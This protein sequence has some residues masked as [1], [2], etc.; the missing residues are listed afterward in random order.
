[1]P[2]APL[3]LALVPTPGASTGAPLPANVDTLSDVMFTAR[4]TLFS[5]SATNMILFT[6]T[7]L[8]AIAAK[9]ACV[10]TPFVSAP[11][12]VEPT[13]V[14]TTPPATRRSSVPSVHGRSAPGVPSPSST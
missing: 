11:D 5:A 7:R 9:V 6:R 3:K 12:A 14:V 2:S 4:T 10:P 13:S 8:V 1:M